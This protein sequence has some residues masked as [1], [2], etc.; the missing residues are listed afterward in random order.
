MAG[1]V[2]KVSSVYET[3]PWGF[4]PGNNFLN[5]AAQ[6]ETSL[7][8]AELLAVIK[9]I[10]SLCGRKSSGTGYS[11]RTLDID[12]LFFDDEIL[13]TEKL[14][15]PHP[16]LYKRRFVLIPLVELSPEMVHPV[17]RKS[18]SQLLASCSDE[19]AVNR[20]NMEI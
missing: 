16:L 2:K 6:L 20:Q 7:E 11:S 14:I 12:I 17:F 10:E 3:E 15:I 13:E 8:P 9:R 18:V 1:A 4:S 5:M 19:K